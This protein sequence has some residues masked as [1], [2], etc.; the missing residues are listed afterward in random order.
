MDLQ[1]ANFDTTYCTNEKC[2]K[3]CFR[4]QSHYIFEKSQTY[5][6]QDYC[7][8]FLERSVSNGKNI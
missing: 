8:D 4:H 6:W 2:S 5:W 7:V 1:K 3:K